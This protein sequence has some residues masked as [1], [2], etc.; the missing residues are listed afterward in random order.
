MQVGVSTDL[1]IRDSY[2]SYQ[3]TPRAEPDEP[4]KS[5]FLKS[6]RPT[7]QVLSPKMG[8]TVS[9]GICL[10]KLAIGFFLY[11][12]YTAMVNLLG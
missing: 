9:L 4:P 11:Q 5:R 8:E 3:S 6:N 2:E 7:V 12:F 10:F 1:D